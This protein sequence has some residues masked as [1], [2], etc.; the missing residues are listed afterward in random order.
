MLINASV[1]RWLN[2]RIVAI[3]A[4]LAVAASFVVAVAVLIE[5]LGLPAETETGGNGRGAI[6]PLF[7]WIVSGNFRV[8]AGI[9]LDQLSILMVLVV[10]GVS[11]VIHVYSAGY[12]KGDE[13]HNRYFTWLNLFV[14]MMLILVLG[15]G[16]LTMYIGW[17]GVGLCS[18]L[19]IGYW[20]EKKT[21]ADAGKKAFLVNRVGDFGFALGI[22]LIFATFGSVA[23][24][25]CA[26]CCRGDLARYSHGHRPLA[27]FGR[28][29]QVGADPALRLVARCD[30]G[31]YAG[32]CA[33]PRGDHGYSGRLYGGP[34]L[35]AF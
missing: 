13:Y 22:M 34:L 3:I 30:G 4:S 2:R 27:L 33:H 23:Y 11:T 19:L 10:T 5:M 28:Y 12:M 26:P 6:I 31:P 1:G 32:E 29:R 35:Y 20:F 15:N 14:F 24:A 25:G 21:A 18:Y 17:E 7:S 8:E 9:L 16:F